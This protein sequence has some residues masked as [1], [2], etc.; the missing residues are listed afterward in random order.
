MNSEF[1]F[2]QNVI[3]VK[4]LNNKKAK[5]FIYDFLKEKNKGCKIGNRN[6][7]S[8]FLCDSSRGIEKI[9]V[10]EGEKGKKVFT[11]IFSQW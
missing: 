5:K 7:T 6:F 1:N 4:K 2:I 10:F 11:F 8:Q 3:D 9:E